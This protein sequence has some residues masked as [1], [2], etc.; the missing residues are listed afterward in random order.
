MI[1]L[2]IEELAMAEALEIPKM[3]MI[4]GVIITCMFFTA[5]TL[6]L[7][8]Y[9]R[10]RTRERLAIIEK[11]GQIE[12]PQRKERKGWG[13]KMGLFL[14]G[15]GIG[16]LVG[17][18]LSAYTALNPDAAYFSM[19]FLFGGAGLVAGNFLQKKLNP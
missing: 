18:L 5:I 9:F 11:G 8:F 1:A 2:S 13:L 19:V 3:G 14:A 6:S 4:T 10:A 17:S 15:I 12:F 7:Y 16:F